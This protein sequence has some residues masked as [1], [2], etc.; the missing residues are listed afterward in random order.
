VSEEEAGIGSRRTC[1]PRP[2]AT[3]ARTKPGAGLGNG[4][5]AMGITALARSHF[6]VSFASSTEQEIIRID[7]ARFSHARVP[8]SIREVFIMAAVDSGKAAK[9]EG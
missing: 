3:S 7:A 1:T 6:G 5:G 2:M 8:S 4:V 9:Q